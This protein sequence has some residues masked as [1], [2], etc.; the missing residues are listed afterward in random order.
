MT[1]EDYKLFGLITLVLLILVSVEPVIAQSSGFYRIQV[2]AFKNPVN[3]ECALNTLRNSGF[4]PSSERYGDFCRVF[5][6]NIRAENVQSIEQALE[7][8]GFHDRIIRPE[9]QVAAQLTVQAPQMAHQSTIQPALRITPRSA[10]QTVPEDWLYRAEDAYNITITGYTGTATTLPIPNEIEG[11]PVTKI[12]NGAFFNK[13]N[14]TEVI[15]PNTVTA[16]EREAFRGCLNLTRITIGNSVI[17]I[18]AGAFACC[19]SLTSVTIPNRVISIEWGAF[20]FFT[21]LTSVTIGKSVTYIGASAFANCAKLI[22]VTFEGAIPSNRFL[23]DVQFPGNLQAVYFTANG[24]SGIYTR[25][26]DG[27][28]WWKQ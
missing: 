1:R 6:P 19:A 20:F 11:L 7:C 18:G 14:L 10:Y 17:S 13:T 21:S 22:N 16:I 23:P 12:G 2:G 27:E 4:N 8:L 9:P 26:N 28:V 24:G 25:L 5:L 15:I 3:A